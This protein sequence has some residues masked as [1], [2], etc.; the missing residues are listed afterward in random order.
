MSTKFRIQVTMEQAPSAW[1][2]H[3]WDR[4]ECLIATNAGEPLKPLH[5]IASGGGDVAG[6]AGAEGDGGRGNCGCEEEEISSAADFGLRRDRYWYRRAGCRGG[7]EEVEDAVEG[8]A[9][10]VYHASSADCRV[11]RSAFSD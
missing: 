1:T 6:N 8:A 10:S 4:V 11:R 5:E 2:A 3:G 7:G 9:G